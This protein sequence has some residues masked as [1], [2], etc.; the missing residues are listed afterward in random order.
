[1]R[2]ARCS[3]VAP[4]HGWRMGAPG[5]HCSCRPSTC[6]AAMRRSPGVNAEAMHG[7]LTSSLGLL[8]QPTW[9]KGAPE[10]LWSC[11]RP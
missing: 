7:R 9:R 8:P 4:A 10:A 11:W 2:R 1:M 5:A 6:G 3:R